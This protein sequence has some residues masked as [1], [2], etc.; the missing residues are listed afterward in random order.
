MPDQA[1]PSLHFAFVGAFRE[2][3]TDGSVGGQLYAC[4]TLVGSDIVEHVRFSTIDTTMRSVPPPPLGRRAVSAAR[5]LATFLT[6]IHRPDIDGALIFTSAGASLVEKS[7]MVLMASGARK[8][9]VLSP[10]S[11]LIEDDVRR[12]PYVARALSEVL[13]RCDAV[14][15]QGQRWKDFFQELAALPEER[16]VV[17][18]NWLD[19][20]HYADTPRGERAQSPVTFLYM[21]WLEPYK[22]ILDLIDALSLGREALANCR[23]IV[24][25]KGSLDAEARARVDELD[26]S[27][28]VEFRGWVVGDEKRAILSEADVLVLPS[29]REGM[30][31]VVLEAMASGLAVVG[32]SV[33]GVPDILCAPSLGVLVEPSNPQMLC[34][35]MVDL[36][37]DHERRLQLGRTARRHIAENHDVN[38]VWP[39][40][41]QALRGE[42]TT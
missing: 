34:D 8:R 25:G 37:H 1:R 30:P 21:G 33:G 14:L 40:V 28:M 35:A 36:A 38:V 6:V 7:V 17:V 3:A 23:V 16:L 42:Q 9:V 32:T 26:L 29:H 24:C 5:R 4:R 20:S 11:G 2:R 15:C 39:R 12:S 19:A 27:G 41:L 22:G 31:N 13:Q 10:R 18:P